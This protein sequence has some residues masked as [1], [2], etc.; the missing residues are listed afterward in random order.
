MN[1]EYKEVL[2][3]KPL[4]EPQLNIL[5]DSRWELVTVLK[6]QSPH[7]GSTVVF[8]SYIFKRESKEIASKDR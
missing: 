5:G 1:I 6:V 4:R 8:W 3:E 2:V 7:P